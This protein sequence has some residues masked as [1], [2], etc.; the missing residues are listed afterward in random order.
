[1]LSIVWRKSL[2]WLGVSTAFVEEGF[3][4]LKMFKELMVG[5]KKLK[6]MLES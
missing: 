6:E 4:H 3:G 2:K 1:M 5:K